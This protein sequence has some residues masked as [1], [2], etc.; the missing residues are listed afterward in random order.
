MT[1]KRR[2]VFE[3]SGVYFAYK[4]KDALKNISLDIAEGESLGIV[5]V[6][7]RPCS[8]CSCGL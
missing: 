4:E 2:N 8:P 5:G 1:E 6:A 3:L 7:K